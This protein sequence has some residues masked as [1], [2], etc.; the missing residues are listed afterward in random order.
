[1]SLF[2]QHGYGKGDK[3]Q[4]LLEDRLASGVV[5]SPA[6]ELADKLAATAAIARGVKASV[7]LDPQLYVSTIP[8]GTASRHEENSLDFSAVRWSAGTELVRMHVDQVL[9]LN[10]RVGTTA[11]IAPAPL[12][13]A[14]LDTWASVSIQYARETMRSTDAPTYVSVA[15]D[16]SALADWAPISQWLN[17]V[18]TL[19]C[20]G[21]YFVV[22]R[23][24]RPYPQLWDP[25]LLMNLLRIV[26]RLGV[27]NRYT[28]LWGFTDVAGL[29]SLA[30]GAT[31]FGCGWFY[32]LRNFT[33][34]KWVPKKG[35]SAPTARV[36]SPGLL[37]P[38]EALSE[39]GQLARSS[40][41]ETAFPD[42]E[43]RSRLSSGEPIPVSEARLQHLQVLGALAGGMSSGVPPRSR[44]D[45]ATL[46][47]HVDEMLVTAREQLL[48]A[49]RLGI[50]L[51]TSYLT[52]VNQLRE[53]LRGF[54]ELEGL[55]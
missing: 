34:S 41:G 7:L 23:R 39:G 8:D 16:E 32:S 22:A 43:L 20:A 11:V 18:T 27:L 42:R 33:R 28:V 35:G 4:R 3:V 25:A 19:D 46:T 9:N 2:V 55:C 5:L 48:E 44:A 31:A 17:E 6:D 30:A 45:A 50:A 52:G 47:A 10:H 53:A 13:T 49:G 26:Y 12:Q 24:D 38:V 37:A 40:I 14:F 36:L 51:A 15:I 29:L 21:F 1:M 54:A